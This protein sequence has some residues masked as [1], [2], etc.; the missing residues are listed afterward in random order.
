MHRAARKMSEQRPQAVMAGWRMGLL[1][2]GGW[3]W[4]EKH[5]LRA[6]TTK[7]DKQVSLF[8]SMGLDLVVLPD[9]RVPKHL[10]NTPRGPYTIWA[11]GLP[12]T[13]HRS[14]A[15]LVRTSWLENGT[16]WRITHVPNAKKTV[17]GGPGRIWCGL[18][19]EKGMFLLAG[20]YF[21]VRR[22]ARDDDTEWRDN[23]RDLEKETKELY[24]IV[25]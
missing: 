14:V 22:G 5:G 7:I 4:S 15:V 16:V 23:L 8:Q 10:W 9:A 12:G 17:V 1:N 11:A 18:R 2:P 21:N 3:G 6:Q 13:A 24:L 19:L 25:C 20:A